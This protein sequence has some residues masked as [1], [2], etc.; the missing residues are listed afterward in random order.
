M[1]CWG[2]SI[3]TR[4]LPV[5]PF[6]LASLTL[7]PSSPHYHDL[8]A[9]LTATYEDNYYSSDA[10][11]MERNSRDF[12]A[13]VNKI[14]HN[15]E[16]LCD[17][18]RDH[19]VTSGKAIT[20]GK[21]PVLT[22]VFYPKY[23]TPQHY[24]ARMRRCSPSLSSSAGDLDSSKA[25]SED[26]EEIKPGYGSLFSLTFTTIEASRAFFDALKCCKGPSLG[27]NFTLACPYTVLAHYLELDWAKSWEVEEG[28]VRVSIGLEDL[29]TLMQWFTLALKEAEATS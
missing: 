13:R 29:S 1:P 15:T 4:Y 27:T 9:T 25:S 22:G 18:L 6:S 7:N 20:E 21:K 5:S 12:K 19:T 28:L 23:I 8:K 10:I 11:F 14:N 26:E 16:T 24:E 17:F 2:S 3:R